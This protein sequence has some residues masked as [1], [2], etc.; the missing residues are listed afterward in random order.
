MLDPAFKK[1]ID[2]DESRRKREETSVELR[3]NKREE[4]LQKRRVKN[5]GSS[6]AGGDENENNSNGS[7]IDNT[8]SVGPTPHDYAGTISDLCHKVSSG[9]LETQI[10]GVIG[11]RTILSIETNPPINEVISAGI[12]PFLVECLKADSSTQ[13]QVICLLKF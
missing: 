10:E 6:V 7:T 5:D 1:G 2:G 12:V 4:M 8:D 9:V 3:K 11:F 13:L